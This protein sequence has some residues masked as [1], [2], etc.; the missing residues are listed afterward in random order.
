MSDCS[1]SAKK[2]NRKKKSKQ[3]IQTRNRKKKSK[4]QGEERNQK[5]KSKEQ[6]E[7]EKHVFL[8]VLIF[9]LLF[10]LFFCK[11]RSNPYLT[12]FKKHRMSCKDKNL[13]LERLYAGKL[14]I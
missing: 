2:G 11:K 10:L 4:K 13:S 8:Q 6:K 14:E 5:K 9:F 1:L 12:F 7:I 3:E